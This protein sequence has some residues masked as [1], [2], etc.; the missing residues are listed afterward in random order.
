MATNFIGLTGSGALFQ[1]DG[2]A[3]WLAK[4]LVTGGLY[5][6]VKFEPLMLLPNGMFPLALSRDGAQLAVS[7]E[8]RYAQIWDM[9][10]LRL[11]LAKLGLQWK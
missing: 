1:P 2:R 9:N 5:D 6:S 10:T 11:E 4:N 8:G 3:I 7:V